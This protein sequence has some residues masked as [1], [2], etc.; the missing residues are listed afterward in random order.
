MCGKQFLITERLKVHTGD[1]S[2]KCKN[3]LLLHL[4]LKRGRFYV[5]TGLHGDAKVLRGKTIDLDLQPGV[6]QHS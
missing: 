2:L 1:K 5:E 3:S 4:C 6:F